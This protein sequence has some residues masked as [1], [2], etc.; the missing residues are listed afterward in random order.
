MTTSRRKA[1]RERM[2]WYG[3]PY[4]VARRKVESGDR[5]LAMDFE[6]EPYE[7]YVYTGGGSERELYEAWVEHLGL[8]ETIDAMLAAVAY[9]RDRLSECADAYWS[10]G[11]LV[12]I[13]D[14]ADRLFTRMRRDAVLSPG[15]DER[16][17][18]AL[19]EFQR[20]YRRLYEDLRWAGGRE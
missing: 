4:N 10:P 14:A 12:D 6:E 13:A 9:V 11:C 3:E 7:E 8:P 20:T 15:D 19:G 18:V 16:L 5:Q 17:L 2:S 1:I